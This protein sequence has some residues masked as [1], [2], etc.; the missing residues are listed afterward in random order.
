MEEEEI[1]DKEDPTKTWLKSTSQR[2]KRVPYSRTQLL[3]LEKE[4]RFNQ[5]V[6]FH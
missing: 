1:E 5:Y 4:F 2:K 6:R 3:E